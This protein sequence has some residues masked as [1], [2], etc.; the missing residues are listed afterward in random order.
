MS[1]QK[2]DLKKQRE[3]VERQIRHYEKIQYLSEL[4]LSKDNFDP[5][6]L[7]PRQLQEHLNLFEKI[8]KT[9]VLLQGQLKEL[10]Y[11]SGEGQLT[12]DEKKEVE[13][14]SGDEKLR[15]ISGGLKLFEDI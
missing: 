2:T 6:T 14:M 11:S 12:P 4:A 1:D 3:Q 13:S 8:S 5:S 7:T 9:L 10:E 15:L